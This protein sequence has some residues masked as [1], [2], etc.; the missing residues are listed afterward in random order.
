MPLA[1]RTAAAFGLGR[2]GLA[3]ARFLQARGAAVVAFD[4][5]PAD[6]FGEALAELRGLGIRALTGV[7]EW[8]GIGSPDLLVVSPGVPVAHP[9]LAAARQAGVE[10]IGEIELAYRFC[11]API[12]AVAG[13]N[14]KGSTTTLLGEMLQAAGLRTVVAGNIGTPLVSVVE[15]DWQVV[16]AEVSSFQL[17]TVV[18]FRPWAAILLNITPD[19]LDR[20]GDFAGYVAAKQRLFT[21][22]ESPD[23]AVL[24]M[25]DPVAAGLGAGVQAEVLGVSA[26]RPDTV[27]HLAADGT[28]IAHLPGAEPIAICDRADLRLN[29][30]HYVIDALCAG[31]VASAAG[32]RTEAMRAAVRSW[33]PAAHLLAEVAVVGGVRFIDDSKATNPG[34]ASADLDTLT[35]PFWVIAGGLNKGLDLTGFAGKLAASARGAFVI[36]EAAAEIAAELAG[37][38]PVAMCA[39]IRQAV[40][41]AYA[42]AGPGEAVI[43]AP[44]CASFDQF[45]D[46]AD[47]GEKFAAAVRALPA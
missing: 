6:R 29:A 1:G 5:G 12:V 42:A 46:Q 20:H 44:A 9:L 8:G 33:R 45:Q 7:G 38:I 34:A 4:E 17:E 35:E 11:A 10:V 28:L 47:R 37:R 22:Q 31:V 30:E 39:D 32:C 43:L 19:H 40:Q 36:G 25:D 27:G 23:L 24:N 15:G 16:V 14:G 41:A 3:S 2:S 13:T 21:N 26:R 18:H